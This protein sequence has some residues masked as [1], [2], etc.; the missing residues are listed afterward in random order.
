MGNVKKT[1]ILVLCL[2]IVYAVLRKTYR[3]FFF[4]ESAYFSPPSIFRSSNQE[5]ISHQKE[6]LLEYNYPRLL[7]LVEDSEKL[8]KAFYDQYAGF[9]TKIK[10]IDIKATK[11][12][13]ADL[14]RE[15]V[16]LNKYL[17]DVRLYYKGNVPV[18]KA[19]TLTYHQKV[20]DKCALDV[21]EI[22]RKA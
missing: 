13:L 11:M 15:K 2:A 9:K 18:K 17:H 1:V 6:Q 19:N 14:Y 12:L 4:Q 3:F 10:P 20:I 16:R 22:L 8:K 7:K 5:Q 21:E